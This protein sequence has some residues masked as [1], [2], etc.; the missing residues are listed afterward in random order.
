[1]TTTQTITALTDPHAVDV[2]ALV[3]D[4]EGRLPDPTRLRQLDT[5]AAQAA[6]TPD[7]DLGLAGVTAA[8]SP[9]DLA[10]ATLTYLH[11]TR[12]DL[13]PVIDHA[14]TLTTNSPEPGT[15]IE[16]LTTAV[17]ALVILAL[18]T[19]VQLERTTTGKWRFK[20]HKKAMSD[21]T[22]GKLLTQ[23]I[24]SYTGRTGQ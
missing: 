23:L 1:V 6:T 22:L 5:Q 21:N 20:V 10:R 15:R 16:P 14:I 3:L 12:P 19:D 7:P 2:L 13:A 17:G 9:G 24:G 18:Q 11:A 8:V 4:R